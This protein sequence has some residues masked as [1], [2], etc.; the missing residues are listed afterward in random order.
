MDDD[1]PGMLSFAEGK[2]HKHVHDQE[3]CRIVI[4]RSHGSDGDISLEY[5]TFELDTTKNTA[6]AGIHYEHITGELKFKHREVE[7]EIVVKI[8]QLAKKEGE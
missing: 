8:L 4:K 2:T 5:E 7:A 6:N 1:R 3:E